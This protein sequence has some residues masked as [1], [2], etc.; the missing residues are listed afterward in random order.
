MSIFGTR[1][2]GPK[3]INNGLKLW[4]DAAQTVSFPKRANPTTGDNWN[5]RASGLTS[6]INN[7]FVNSNF[8]WNS[9][10]GGYF[11]EFAS[12]DNYVTINSPSFTNLTGVTIQAAFMYTAGQFEGPKFLNINGSSGAVELGTGFG[13]SDVGVILYGGTRIITS[14]TQNVW[15]FASATIS[16]P[17]QSM[18]LRINGNAR[19]T[20]THGSSTNINF[21][22]GWMISRNA[23]S[24]TVLRGRLAA[25][26]FYDRALSADEE[27]QNFNTYRIRYG[28]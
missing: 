25:V 24:G 23:T 1:D 10:N 7:G 5:D 28:I 18:S 2:S 11:E 12:N 8:L 17:G 13:G 26:L 15:N 20:N 21:T 27:L 19:S 3:V 6:T 16:I 9:A 4:F 22:S 14:V